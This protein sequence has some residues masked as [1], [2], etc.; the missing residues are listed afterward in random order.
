MLG[1]FRKSK[2]ELPIEEMTRQWVDQRW[3]WL[4]TEFGKDRLL[5]VTQILPNPN[6]SPTPTRALLK[7]CG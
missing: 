1:W 2:V 5:N 6:F 3:D 7:T 4:L